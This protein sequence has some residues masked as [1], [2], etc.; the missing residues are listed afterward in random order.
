MT[1]QSVVFVDVETTGVDVRYHH[2][3]EV[4]L[5]AHDG[6]VLLDATC[7][8]DMDHADE[9]ALRV[10]RFFDRFPQVR[11]DYGWQKDVRPAPTSWD[12]STLALAV[13]KFTAGKQLAAACVS[14]DAKF[15]TKLLH[16]Q[17]LTP[18][19]DYHL[20]D[21]EA[22]AAG[23]LGMEPPWRGTKVTEAL[24]VPLPED[25]HT[26][27]ADARWHREVYLAAYDL[28]SAA[29]TPPRPRP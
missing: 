16:G 22:V 11:R 15:L 23:A 14:T 21:V 26:A 18:A 4:A 25:G 20:V 8:V 29:A 19:W 5:V 1:S 6:S 27:L 12:R 3:F 9:N 24:G 2:V 10:N 7:D 28:P 13:A 17:N